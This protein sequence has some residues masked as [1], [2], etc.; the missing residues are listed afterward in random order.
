MLKQTLG[1]YIRAE[2]ENYM[3]LSYLSDIELD[4]RKATIVGSNVFNIWYERS[5][6]MRRPLS[7]YEADNLETIVK[8]LLMKGRRKR[9]PFTEQSM[10]NAVAH[11]VGLINYLFGRCYKEEE[12][13]R[14]KKHE[15][16]Y[17]DYYKSQR[18]ENDRYR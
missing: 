13:M 1:Q 12:E 14:I 3:T 18:A 9:V 11:G 5:D 2:R 7:E 16:L 4:R 6:T 8:D 10:A 15:D 17:A